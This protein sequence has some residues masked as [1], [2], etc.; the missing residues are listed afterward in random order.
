M[1]TSCGGKEV[2][3]RVFGLEDP[4]TELLLEGASE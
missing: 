2:L 3:K 1:D 4:P